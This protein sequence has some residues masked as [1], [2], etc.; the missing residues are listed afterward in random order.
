[1]Y[2]IRLGA[3]TLAKSDDPEL[4]A[5]ASYANGMLEKDESKAKICFQNALKIQLEVVKKK[6]KD[7][8]AKSNL[9]RYYNTN[10][11]T[12]LALKLAE[13]I[14]D[15]WLT[16]LYLNNIGYAKVLNGN[17]YESLEYFFRSLD[18]CISNRYKTLL[19]NTYDNIARAYRLMGEWEKSA[20]YLYY[21]HFVEATLFEEEFAIQASFSRA[22]YESEKKELENESLKEEQKILAENLEFEKI[23][24]IILTILTLIVLFISF[25]IYYS[26]RKIKAAK[27]LLDQ[28][29][30]DILIQ[31]G[32]LETL[33]RVLKTSEENLKFAQSIAKTANWELDI[34]N[35]KFSFSEQLPIIYDVDAQL[36][37]S[38]F[39]QMI[40]DK[41]HHDDREQFNN[42]YEH[43]SDAE[44]VE[45]EYR[46]VNKKSI[47]WIKT[48]RIAIRDENG[49]IDKVFGTVQDITD[50]K[51][52]EEI[53]LKLAIQQSFA[54]QL[55][56]SQE[57][58]RKRIA[59]ELHDGLGQDILL[60]KNRAQLCLQ[61]EDLDSFTSEQITEI[62]NSVSGILKIIREMSLN[63][64]PAHLERIGLTETIVAVIQNIS[65]L[66]EINIEQSIENIDKLLPSDS[67]I[68]FFRIVQEGFNNIVKHS[69]AKNAKIE[70]SV[71]DN[72]ISMN[73]I[74]DGKGFKLKSEIE[75]PGG[76]GLN[77][78]LNR[79]RILNGTINISSEA[80]KGTKLEITIPVAKSGK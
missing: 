44:N 62:S 14:N 12:E 50:S 73:I 61:N 63:L 67:E 37:K 40:I 68:N 45:V 80:A 20:Y 72:N 39:R 77:N 21:M 59:G 3:E 46:I 70:I 19:R 17:P 60:I 71:I 42:Y 31:K 64:R 34:K 48:K 55:I 51:E 10:G 16:V 35:N 53:K 74:D 47:R 41:I 25:Y 69:G 43:L 49:N 2:Y 1:M 18:I 75:T 33:N 56:Q 15:D 9:S 66:T 24:K 58:E 28:T 8:E 11:K 4:I 27:L 79:I 57:E 36:L 23:Q 13:E 38:D 78:M 22:K 30:N 54:K 26:R 7:Y 29:H 5:Y 76:F 65:E 52:E 32:E 6:P